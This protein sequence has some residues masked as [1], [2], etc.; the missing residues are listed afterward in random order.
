MDDI[1]AKFEILKKQFGTDYAKIESG[2]K[3]WYKGLP[4][5]H[6]AKDHAHYNKV[7]KN[8]IFFASDI[9]WPGGGGPKY[10]VLHPMTKRPVKIPSRGWITNEATMKKWI[11]EGR[12]NFGDDETSVPTIK[13]YLSEH[14][15]GVPY[16]VFYKDGRAASK[17][18]ATL[19][20]DKVFENPKDE[21]IIQRFIEFSGTDEGDIVLDF[22]SGSGTTAHALFLA[23]IEQ[24]KSRKFILVQLQEAIDPTKAG[25]EKSKKV[26][27]NAV[28]L[29]D[30]I[31]APYNICEIGKER[32]RRAGAKIKEEA[33]LTAANLDVGFRVL[34]LDSTNMKPVYYK[35]G[36]YTPSLFD[37]LTDNIKEDRTPEDLLF[38]VMLER[39]VLLSSS[40]EEKTIDGKRVFFVAG[41]YLV[42]CFDSDLDEA[43]ITAIAKTEPY[44]FV[45]RESAFASDSAKTDCEQLF[46]VYSQGTEWWVM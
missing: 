23:N 2:L 24:S 45:T 21:E 22:F 15:E 43:T 20:G 36:D 34:K 42:A 26:A 40:M 19:L 11:S 17:R 25:S 27:Q 46:K 31:N 14:E 12:I 33:G 35:P 7:D 30:S 29:L 8:G 9:S 41:N 44:Y 1:Y 16:S 28:K 10:S 13:S 3:A 32:I 18:L 38:Q 39:G 4:D 6:P 5:G 37:S